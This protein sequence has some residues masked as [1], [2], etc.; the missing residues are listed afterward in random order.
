MKSSRP[1]LGK[2]IDILG[3]G[4]SVKSTVAVLLAEA[5]CAMAYEICVLDA[6]STNMGVHRAFG[7]QKAPASLIDFF[8]GCATREG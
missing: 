8:G 6:D 1:L 4:A 2:C 5:L 3:K 7:L